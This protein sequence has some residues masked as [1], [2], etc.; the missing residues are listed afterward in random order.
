MRDSVDDA[1]R[2]LDRLREALTSPSPKDLE[3]TIPELER[4]VQAMAAS[5]G[6]M[7]QDIAQGKAIDAALRHD[8]AALSGEIGVVQRLLDRGRELCKGRA[9]LVA[10]AAGGYGASGKPAPLR[11]SSSIKIEG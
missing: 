11:P 9:I 3:G 10:I 8:V 7:Q 5:V 1:R 2:Q 4:A 6:R